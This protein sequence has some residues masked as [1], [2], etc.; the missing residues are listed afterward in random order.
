MRVPGGG[1][2]GCFLVK[3]KEFLNVITLPGGFR[4][5]EGS[6]VECHYKGKETKN[7]VLLCASHCVGYFMFY[8]SEVWKRVTLDSTLC[9]NLTGCLELLYYFRWSLF[10]GKVQNVL[11]HCFSAFSNTFYLWNTMV[12]IRYS[13][14]FCPG[15]A[16][17]DVLS[18]LFVLNN[19]KWIII[20][21]A[22]SP[23][24]GTFL[25][26]GLYL[27]LFWKLLKSFS[28]RG[29]GGTPFVFGG[30]EIGNKI[31]LL[32]LGQWESDTWI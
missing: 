24:G 31:F 27:I 30:R 29:P 16:P 14:S 19:N 23:G 3:N 11:C 4:L 32:H 1:V 10:R 18:F 13:S 28:A 22:M 8:P 5:F 9:V 2:T 12:F 26:L 25:K 21:N 7:D 15:V 20:P 6:S 17:T